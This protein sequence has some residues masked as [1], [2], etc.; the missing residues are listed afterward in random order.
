MNGIEESGHDSS[1]FRSSRA[2]VEEEE[3]QSKEWQS[4]VVELINDRMGYLTVRV[5][6]RY[7]IFGSELR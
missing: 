6:S 1:L 4:R 2:R 5:Y 3:W 7:L